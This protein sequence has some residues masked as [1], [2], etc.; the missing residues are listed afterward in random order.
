MRLTC[1]NTP[2]IPSDSFVPQYEKG[3]WYGPEQ[4]LQ[5]QGL[6]GHHQLEGHGPNQ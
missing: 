1:G 4:S 5:T 3:R 2:N 6:K